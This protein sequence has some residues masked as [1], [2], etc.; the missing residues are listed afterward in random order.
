MCVRVSDFIPSRP[1]PVA[2]SFTLWG[3]YTLNDPRNRALKHHATI[4]SSTI[5]PYH[6]LCAR[7]HDM[8]YTYALKPFKRL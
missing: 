2:S 1:R 7:T 3:V 4:E 6:A 5:T 8:R